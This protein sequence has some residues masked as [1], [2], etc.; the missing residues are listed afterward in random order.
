MRRILF[1]SVVL[2][3]LH[4]NS[5]EFYK[6][7]LGEDFILYKK[8]FFKLDDNSVLSTS[9]FYPTLN[10]AVAH[11]IGK[12]VLYATKEHVWETDKDS[13]KGRVF[14]VESIFTHK[15]I[16]LS[17]DDKIDM[18]YYDKPIFCLKDTLNGQRI[19]Y[20]YNQTSEYWFDFLCNNVVL[21][22]TVLS[23]GIERE[24]DKYNGKV[25]LY[26]PIGK[27]LIIY[28]TIKNKVVSYYLS[29]HTIGRTLNVGK[30]GVNLLFSDGTK[31]NKQAKIDVDVNSGGGWKYSSYI[32]L[33][34]NDL[35]LFSTK[36]VSS[37]RLYIYDNE[38]ISSYSELFKTYVQ[39][40]KDMN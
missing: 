12:P 40:I 11:D 31:W 32:K 7:Y 3:S 6:L 25:E 22:K 27:D 33:N 5:Q 19:Y 24:V 30:V 21:D 35:R 29:L 15:G 36:N 16:P 2:F 34:Q 23:K 14:L 8:S 10:D 39:T 1:L 9:S 18:G 28:K 4:A 37:F 38:V 26:S 20:R 17:K 13:I